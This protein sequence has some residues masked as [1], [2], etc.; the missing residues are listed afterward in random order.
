M[1]DDN[2]RPVAGAGQVLE[3]VDLDAAENAE[4]QAA[5]AA[6]GAGKMRLEGRRHIQPRAKR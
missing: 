3:A 5:E 2:Q 6:N 1:V 4:Q